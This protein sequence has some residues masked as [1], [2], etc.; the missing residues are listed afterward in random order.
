MAVPLGVQGSSSTGAGVIARFLFLHLLLHLH[1]SSSN[2]SSRHHTQQR[3]QRQHK[4]YNK[5]ESEQI[6]DLNCTIGTSGV[7]SAVVQWC[8][9]AVVVA[10]SMLLASLVPPVSRP[11]HSMVRRAR[12]QGAYYDSNAPP[13]TPFNPSVLASN[14][15]P[16]LCPPSLFF[17]FLL[18]I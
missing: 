18:K 8:R 9:S 5:S 7:R 13:F 16:A 1:L 11:V 15:P 3:D 10:A 2:A 4:H 6:S 12:N 14:A 17:T